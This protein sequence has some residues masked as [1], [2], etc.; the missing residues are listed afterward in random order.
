M[1]DAYSLGS[2]NIDSLK[3]TLLFLAGNFPFADEAGKAA[4]NAQVAALDSAGNPHETVAQETPVPVIATE[5]LSPEMT[6]EMPAATT[7]TETAPETIPEAPVPGTIPANEPAVETA[8]VEATEDADQA[9][10]IADLEA[11]LA[12]A[13][14]AQGGT[15]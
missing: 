7:T 12:A 8:D 11:Q 10:K 3:E 14:A 5:T 1:A 6:G 13:R 9:A 2:V 15:A 4:F